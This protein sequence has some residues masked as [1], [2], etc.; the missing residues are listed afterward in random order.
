MPIIRNAVLNF[1][2]VVLASGIQ[3]APTSCPP[4]TPQPP[5]ASYRDSAKQ[6]SSELPNL[7]LAISHENAS[8]LIIQLPTKPQQLT[9]V[10]KS[11]AAFLL[12]L[13]C[14]IQKC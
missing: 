3:A 12:R 10:V 8:E 13:A 14:C 11:F 5:F 7:R 9:G 4:S 2:A 1:F 6:L